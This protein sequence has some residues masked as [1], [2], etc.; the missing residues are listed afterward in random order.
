M[1]LTGRIAVE[2]A[3]VVAGTVEGEILGGRE[4]I[5]GKTADVRQRGHLSEYDAKD[6]SR[7]GRGL[8]C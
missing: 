8:S 3:A 4:L 6:I 1:Q 5:I 7:R 2:E